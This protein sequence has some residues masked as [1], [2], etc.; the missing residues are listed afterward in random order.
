MHAV[1]KVGLF[2]WS[3]EQCMVDLQGWESHS[4][5][6]TLVCTGVSKRKWD[7]VEHLQCFIG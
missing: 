6:L 1:V 5:C 4:E 7:I 3:A 2:I